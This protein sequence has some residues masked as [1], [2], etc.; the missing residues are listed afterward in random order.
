M[1]PETSLAV[2]RRTVLGTAL[3]ALLLVAGFA[4]AWVDIGW[5]RA[6]VARYRASI[7]SQVLTSA[8]SD[9]G[10]GFVAAGILAFGAGCALVAVIAE[11]RR[12]ADPLGRHPVVLVVAYTLL[13]V[14]VAIGLTEVF[15]ACQMLVARSW[16]L[17]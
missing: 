8:S 13:L 6:D 12:C 14:N 9:S 3:A 17:R 15:V 2:S 4:L 1:T 10:A 16:A 7:A 11:R 5:F